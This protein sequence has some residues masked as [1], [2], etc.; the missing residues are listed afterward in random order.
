MLLTHLKYNLFSSELW[1]GGQWAVCFEDPGTSE[2]MYMYMCYE[3]SVCMF[4]PHVHCTYHNVVAFTPNFETLTPHLLSGAHTPTLHPPPHIPT[5]TP[6]IPTHPHRCSSL[7]AV[8][9]AS[10]SPTPPQLIHWVWMWRRTRYWHYWVTTGRARP[11]PS[12]CL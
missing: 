5:H 9:R 10:R 12:T 2:G 8:A 4:A 1:C 3:C 11:P 7:A 6:H